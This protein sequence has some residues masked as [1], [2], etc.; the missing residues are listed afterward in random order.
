MRKLAIGC[1]A[2]LLV[3]LGAAPA[4]AS[5]IAPEYQ[6][7]EPADGATVHQPPDRIEVTFSEPLDPGSSMTVTD[8]CDHRVD[9][10][11][12]EVSGSSMSIGLE[13]KPSGRYLVEY[14]A[15]GIGGL[16]G[17]TEGSFT[18][19]AHAGA[20]CDGDK[21]G[22]PGHDPGGNGNHGNGNHGNGNHGA[23]N[24]ANGNHDGDDHSSGSTHSGTDHSTMGTSAHTDHEAGDSGSH[25][26]EGH[27]GGNHDDR[28]VASGPD[29]IDGI[30][31][32]DT[33]RELLTR[34]DSTTLLISLALCAA[35]GILGGVVL[36][37]TGAK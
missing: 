36:R 30:T 24:H 37:A 26:N 19:T 13:K 16:T 22:H 27:A 10:G 32:S 25:S 17:E 18:F 29:T 5:Q 8:A 7:S 1:Y 3:L 21:S 20:P 23:G 12:T 28:P 31:S 15:S 35:L 4:V 11:A 14:V 9:D 6:S 34:A 2:V 33:Q